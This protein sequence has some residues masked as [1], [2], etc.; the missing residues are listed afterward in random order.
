[1]RC[2][3]LVV[4]RERNYA[5]LFHSFNI[6]KI[7]AYLTDH[8]EKNRLVDVKEGGAKQ[9][10][11][12]ASDDS[13]KRLYSNF[14]S[15]LLLCLIPQCR[16]VH[17]H[18]CKTLPSLNSL[19]DV[20]LESESVDSFVSRIEVM[21]HSSLRV[22][23]DFDQTLILYCVT[24]G[25]ITNCELASPSFEPVRAPALVSFSSINP[26]FVGEPAPLCTPSWHPY[27]W[28]FVY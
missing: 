9:W 16:I 18:S 17:R 1:V 3:V 24:T 11:S 25:E 12:V 22:T 26:W 19:T 7:N 14:L 15:L 27:G 20:P 10:R 28:Y 2:S 4:R 21:Q 8:I 23:Y 13:D 5:L 6:N